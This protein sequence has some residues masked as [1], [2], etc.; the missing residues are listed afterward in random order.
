MG[1]QL[2]E[3][4]KKEATFTLKQYTKEELNAMLDKVEADFKAGSGIP[5]EEV[6]R[7]V[8]EEQDGL[9]R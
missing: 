7:E 5:S 6:W 9:L 3:H 2:I 8:D 1:E 4:A